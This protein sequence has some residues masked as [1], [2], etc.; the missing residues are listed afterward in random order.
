MRTL[1]IVAFITILTGCSDNQYKEIILGKWETVEWNEIQTGSTINA[2]MDFDFGLDGRYTVNYG[3]EIEKGKYWISGDY[4]HTLED[5]ASEKKVKILKMS[6]D[7]FLMEMNR[8]GSI[9]Q[10]LL[11]R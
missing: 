6:K 4:L 7:T 5:G 10:V 1:I 2:T 3:T 11:S 8:A 9:E